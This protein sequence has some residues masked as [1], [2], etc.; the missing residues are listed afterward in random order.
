MTFYDEHWYLYLYIL[1]LS[2]VVPFIYFESEK[3]LLLMHS[4]RQNVIHETRTKILD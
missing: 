3:K 1:L 4:K 2:I